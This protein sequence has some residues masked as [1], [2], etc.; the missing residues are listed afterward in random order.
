MRMLATLW[1]VSVGLCLT[2]SCSADSKHDAAPA[3]HENGIPPKKQVVTFKSGDLSLIGFLFKP[4]GS[5][6]FPTLIW[7]HGSERNPGLGEQFDTVASIFVPA[8]Y[9]VFAPVRRG[10][11]RSEGTYIV[12]SLDQARLNEG[13]DAA[14]QLAVHLLE[15][16]QLGDQLA[17]LEYAKQLP[18]V[19]SKRLAV[20]GCSYG[21]IQALLGAER[22]P[23]YRAAISISP[24]ALSWEHNPP[25]RERLAE[26]A[27]RIGIPVLLIQPAKDASLEPS[28]VLGHELE[29]LG[30]DFIG[31]VYPADG[32][33]KEQHHC[34][35]GPS[36][37]H[38]W[39]EDAKAFLAEHLR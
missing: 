11:G 34:F 33:E 30:A 4:E 7:N 8:G 18:Y 1:M 24:G 39:A 32:P 3:A 25:L 36:G 16:E 13:E 15:T 22:N 21:G 10:H 35:G 31:K 29:H 23:G 12:S 28:R 37:M 9:V 2:A 5:G 26:A 6:P 14:N 20:A 38:V 19:D 17:G 27:R